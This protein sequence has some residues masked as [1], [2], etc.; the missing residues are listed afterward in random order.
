MNNYKLHRESLIVALVVVSESELEYYLGDKYYK[1][2]EHEDQANFNSWLTSMGVDI[3]RPIIKQKNIKH[4]NR[5]NQV[6]VCDRWVCEERQ[7]PEWIFSG[8]A[9]KEAKDRYSG[10]QIVEDLY[11]SRNLTL[12][13]QIML[14]DRDKYSKIDES[15]WEE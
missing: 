4:R 10:N 5:L 15:V 6:V 3:N 14:E 1:G 13:A 2:V 8:Y 7:D 11:R 12:D 9:S